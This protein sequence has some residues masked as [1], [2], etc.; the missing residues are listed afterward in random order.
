MYDSTA[1]PWDHE[2]F[3][4]HDRASS[5]VGNISQP[6]LSILKGGPL[7]AAFL[8][9]LQAASASTRIA[10]GL[11]AAT[12]SQDRTL[13]VQAPVPSVNSLA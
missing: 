3:G 2:L 9:F 4:Q 5:T 8:F 1:V 12:P 10:S 6:T 7:A 11:P 13:P